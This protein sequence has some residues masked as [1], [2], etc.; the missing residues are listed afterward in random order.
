MPTKKKTTTKKA[1]AKRKAPAKKSDAAGS[2]SARKAPAKRKPAA[3]KKAPVV[4][5][6]EMRTPPGL[7]VT[8]MPMGHT[9]IFAMLMVSVF[10]L[11]SV[12]TIATYK[13]QVQQHTLDAQAQEIQQLKAL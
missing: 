10:A 11:A 5:K 9:Q 7:C 4:Q 6:Q 13:L 12:L 2:A 1:P 3:K 8:C